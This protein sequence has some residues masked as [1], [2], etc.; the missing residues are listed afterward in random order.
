MTDKLSDLLKEKELI[1]MYLVV[2][3]TLNMSQGKLAAQCAHGAQLLT[4]KY[5]DM[6]K[7]YADYWL[8]PTYLEYFEDWVNADYG[9]I[10]LKADLK[11]WSKLKELD[12]EN[13]DH[14]VVVDNGLTEIAAGS[15]T[16]IAFWPM[17]KSNVPK[18]IKRLQVLK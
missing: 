8:P 10:V 4:M 16:C 13:Y 1:R 7:E 11:E 14:I 5:F 3:E 6:K 12:K 15:E 17:Y 2:N 18:V 9:K